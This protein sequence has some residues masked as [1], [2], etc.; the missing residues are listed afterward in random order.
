MKESLKFPLIWWGFS[1]RVWRFILIFCF[2]CL[3]PTILFSLGGNTASSIPYGLFFAVINSILEEVLWRGFIL[4][5][6]IDYIGE[7][8]GLIL[9]SIAFGFYHLS[10]GFSI[11]VCLAFAVGGFYMGGIAI[12]SRGL[13]APIIMHFFVNMAFLSFGIIL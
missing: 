10:Y 5:R 6:V 7:K 4:G 11:W 8:Q 12:K 3:I 13:L 2:L 9:S 1:E